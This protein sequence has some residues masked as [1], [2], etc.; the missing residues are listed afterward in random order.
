MDALV[1]MVVVESALVEMVLGA[2]G[3][4]QEKAQEASK[5]GTL[6]FRLRC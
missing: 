5:I 1:E 4:C 3:P 2:E 6:R